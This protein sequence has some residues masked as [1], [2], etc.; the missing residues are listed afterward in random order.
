MRTDRVQIGR[1]NGQAPPAGTL[2]ARVR[3]VEYQGTYV[4]LGLA[5]D[6]ASELVA[7][8]PEE[9]FFADPLNPGDR[10]SVSWRPGDAHQLIDPLPA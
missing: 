7:T 2:E 8:M 9:A 4:Q 1:L 3:D 5:S 6:G 10:V